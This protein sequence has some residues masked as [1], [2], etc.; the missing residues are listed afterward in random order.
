MLANVAIEVEVAHAGLDERVCLVLAHLED[1][2][3]ALQVEHDAARVDRRRAA[4]GEIAPG[5]DRVERNRVAVRDLDD[6]LNLRHGLGRDSRGGDLLAGLA[7][8]RR[9]RVAIRV[10]GFVAREHPVLA[11][12]GT[13]LLDGRGEIGRADPW[14]SSHCL[15]PPGGEMSAS[16]IA[17]RAC[18]GVSCP[19]RGDWRIYDEDRCALRR[20]L[21][22][23]A[24]AVRISIAVGCQSRDGFVHATD[25]RA[26]RRGRR[27]PGRRWHSTSLRPP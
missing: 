3:H 16:S 17:A 12:S 24:F 20:G 7:P 23:V 6:L 2:V 5:R 19:R 10:H 4:V 15:V 27:R 25:A 26:G 18:S 22:R 14:R 13:E 9:V 21:R 8:E 11:D 1:L